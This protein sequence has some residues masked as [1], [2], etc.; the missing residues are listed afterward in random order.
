MKT[1]ADLDGGGDDDDDGWEAP[2]PLRRLQEAQ[3]RGWTG[4]GHL[5]VDD[6]TPGGA[7]P[8]TRSSSRHEYKPHRGSASSTGGGGGGGVAQS[9]A[10]RK[11]MEDLDD[12]FFNDEDGELR[13]GADAFI[14]DTAKFEAMEAKMER[15]RAG[16]AGGA[17]AN[18]KR[19]GMSAQ[20]SALKDDQRAWEENRLLTS[21]AASRTAVDLEFDADVRFLS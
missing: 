14:G 4:K 17:R 3:Q 8:A 13:D 18:T 20:R 1:R 21:G 19:R 10:D 2:T 11:L 5:V 15:Q 12:D 7:T 6:E 9:E 16:K